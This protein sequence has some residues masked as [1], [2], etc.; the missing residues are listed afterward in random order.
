MIETIS[1]EPSLFPLVAFDQI[2][3]QDANRCLRLWSHAMGELHRPMNGSV[4]SG[5]G[6][7][8]HGLI[9]DGRVVGVCTTSTLITPHVAG[10]P[11]MTRAN[12]VELS[13]LCAEQRDICRVVLRLWRLFVFESL[14][15]EFAISYQDRALHRGDLY[16]FD[17]WEKIATSRSGTDKRSGR[18]GRNKNVWAWPRSKP[19]NSGGQ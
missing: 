6:D 18:K 1:R 12:T 8:A 13:R 19:T 4:L 3:L 14:P 16:R 2:S 10:H 17:G 11:N 15:H 7:V 5:G 9:H